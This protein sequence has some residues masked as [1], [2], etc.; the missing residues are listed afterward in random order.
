MLVI[1]PASDANLLVG[2][3]ALQSQL[4]NR[5]HLVAAVRQWVDGRSTTLG[6]I[7]VA[8]RALLAGDLAALKVLV[9]RLLE[10]H[11]DDVE[12]TLAAVSCLRSVRVPLEGVA[13]DDLRGL[14]Q[15]TGAMAD[16]GEKTSLGTEAP[17][18]S[19]PSAPV[20]PAASAPTSTPTTVLPAEPVTPASGP[21]FHIERLLVEGNLGSLFLARDQE[22]ARD[23]VVK[24][25]HARFVDDV[26]AQA[27][28]H[29]EVKY[30]A[31]LEHSG[32][33]PIYGAGRH[34]DGRRYYAM[35]YIKGEEM[36]TAIDR[37]HQL[38]RSSARLHQVRLLLP[39]FAAVCRAIAHA[40]DRGVLHRDIKPE[41]VMLSEDGETIVIDWGLAKSIDSSSTDG[42]GEATLVH[43]EDEDD[44]N[45]TQQFQ[46]IGTL[47]YMSPETAGGELDRVG[48]R[49]DVFSLGATLYHLLTGQAPFSKS[50]ASP[51]PLLS[52]VQRGDYPKPRE[53]WPDLPRGLEAICL[54]AMSVAPEKRYRSARAMAEEVERWLEG[55]PVHAMPD[56]L[57]ERIARR[58]RK[59]PVRLAAIA[60]V[61]FCAIGAL[62]GYFL[63]PP[64]L[65]SD[66]ALP[67]QTA[68]L[69]TQR[70]KL[71]DALRELADEKQQHATTR[72][73]ADSAVARARGEL[74]GALK[75]AKSADEKAHEFKAQAE[76]WR[77]KHAEATTTVAAL[78][79]QVAQHLTD[80][81]NT[82]AQKQ[83][84]HQQADVLIREAQGRFD[85]G[86]DALFQ[87]FGAFE[88]RLDQPTSKK[89]ELE[90]QFA[91]ARLQRRLA[92]VHVLLENHDSGELEYN[93]AI[94]TFVDMESG[95]KGK[96]LGEPLARAVS[97][98]LA[99]A[100]HNLA[101]LLATSPALTKR[102]PRDAVTLAEKAA[103]ALPR[104]DGRLPGFRLTYG[105]ALFRDNKLAKARDILEN[106]KQRLKDAP[107][108]YDACLLFLAMTEWQAGNRQDAEACFREAQEHLKD[109]PVNRELERFR[110]EAEELLVE[111]RKSL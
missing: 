90:R 93:N 78:T 30:A 91:F 76:S 27:R 53:V 86:C 59:R 61:I 5:Q 70:A 56:P 40:H 104:D 73:G 98:Q 37:C 13:D 48:P 84:V 26:E 8:R 63:R 42:G 99:I 2:L 39:R 33:V 29:R 106:A 12:R 60:A 96:A 54:K 108:D 85:Q 81:Q 23:V 75:K 62:G 34:A 65:E 14:L 32:I 6:E 25:I 22:L 100:R 68:E 19:Q 101:W 35:R 80:L 52:K 43:R 88:K 1:N 77:R 47:A 92:D 28:F 10:L 57:P 95:A 31:E 7:L 55:E 83:R 103:A 89:V 36:R 45:P 87:A 15:R 107:D 11:S 20:K 41:N 4:I 69:E 58:L 72:T 82:R 46:A 24:Q 21:R 16:P 49:S 44:Y 3:L 66:A 79:K 18:P 110:T 50:A 97:E 94:G 17:A 111:R 105:I 9:T 102:K 109:R 74:D 51:E 67:T 38:E 71:N 64:G